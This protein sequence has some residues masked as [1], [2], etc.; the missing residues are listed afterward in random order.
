MISP[1]VAGFVDV[2]EQKH[3]NNC[4]AMHDKFVGQIEAILNQDRSGQGSDCCKKLMDDIKN[5]LRPVEQQA[6][7]FKDSLDGPLDNSE[8]LIWN[9]VVDHYEVIPL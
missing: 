3:S 1:F 6:V 8:R 5:E 9:W 2:H 4:R 7:Q